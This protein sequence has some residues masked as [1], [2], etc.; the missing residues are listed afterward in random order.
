MYFLDDIL[1]DGAGNHIFAVL[2]IIM[3]GVSGYCL[4]KRRRG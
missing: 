4:D 2:I 3:A 1:W